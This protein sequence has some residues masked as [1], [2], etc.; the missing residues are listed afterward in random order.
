MAAP[1][2]VK[3]ALADQAVE[4]AGY[5]TPTPVELHRI[6]R[7]MAEIHQRLGRPHRLQELGAGRARLRHDVE[8]AVAPVAR[9]LA[10][11]RGGLVGRGGVV[12]RAIDG[13]TFTR[14]P[15]PE[16]SDLASVQA[17]GADAAT[18]GSAILPSVLNW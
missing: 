16:A 9:H 3:P 14:V 12:L 7:E 2:A 15:F 10:A 17:T 13:R 18:G 4:A 6:L 11:A 8:L 5:T 1:S